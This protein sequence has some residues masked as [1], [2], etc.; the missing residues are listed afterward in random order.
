MFPKMPLPKYLYYNTNRRD[1]NICRD[2]SNSRD[3]NNSRNHYNSVDSKNANGSKISSSK[4]NRSITRNN[5]KLHQKDVCNSKDTINS[6]LHANSPRQEVSNVV[7]LQ[8]L[9]FSPF[10]TKKCGFNNY[11]FIGSAQL[12]FQF[13]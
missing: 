6:R 8:I 11:R 2:D 3:V 7:F 12:C 13:Q 1:V 10:D 9:H 5:I 4:A